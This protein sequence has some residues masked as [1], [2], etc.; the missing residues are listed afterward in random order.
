VAAG[1]SDDEEESSNSVES[2]GCYIFVCFDCGGSPFSRRLISSRLSPKGL[3]SSSLAL[4][5]LSQVREMRARHFFFSL[6]EI[7]VDEYALFS[8]GAREDD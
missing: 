6:S 3:I 8:L 7:L 1:L 2:T 4:V 5:R